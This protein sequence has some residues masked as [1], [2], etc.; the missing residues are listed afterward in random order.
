MPIL[1]V[2]GKKSKFLSEKAKVL[3]PTQRE[4][5]PGT[6]FIVNFCGTRDGMGQNYQYLAQNDQNCQFTAKFGHFWDK[7]P[8]SF[9]TN[10]TE[11]PHTHLVQIVIWS[12]MGSN[13]QKMTIFGKKKQFWANFGRFWAKNPNFYGRK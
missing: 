5:Q 11:K 1:V 6:L 9:G 3:V 2:L 4:N 10:I 12:S 7:N 8:Y 13:W